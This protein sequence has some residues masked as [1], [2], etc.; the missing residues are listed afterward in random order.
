MIREGRGESPLRMGLTRLWERDLIGFRSLLARVVCSNGR[1][2]YMLSARKNLNRNMIFIWFDG[3]SKTL[4]KDSL[5]SC[6]GGPAI[7]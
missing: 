3:L 2:L 5:I 6:S 4:W 1:T 7:S